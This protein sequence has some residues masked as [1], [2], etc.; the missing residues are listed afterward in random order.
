MYGYCT[1]K[2]TFLGAPLHQ[3]SLLRARLG[4]KSTYG[5]SLLAILLM[6]FNDLMIFITTQKP[7]NRGSKWGLDWFSCGTPLNQIWTVAHHTPSTCRGRLHAL[8]HLRSK[9]RGVVYVPPPTFSGD[10]CH[11]HNLV[12]SPLKPLTALNEKPYNCVESKWWVYSSG[13]SHTWVFR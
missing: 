5:E 8:P 2:T 1:Q 4:E 10:F 3:Y 13:S 11:A 9:L 6:R 12:L 7:S